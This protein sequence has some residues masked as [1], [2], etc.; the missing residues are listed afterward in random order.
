MGI[1]NKES[2]VLVKKTFLEMQNSLNEIESKILSGEAD[3]DIN[4]ISFLF[5]K[6]WENYKLLILLLKIDM[7][8]E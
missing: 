8:E 2:D 5:G 3:V 7:R 4:S 1:T 6:V